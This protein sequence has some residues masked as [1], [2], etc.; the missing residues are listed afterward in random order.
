MGGD[1]CTGITLHHVKAMGSIGDM[2]WKLCRG[3]EGSRKSIFGPTGAVLWSKALGV[4]E[5]F[6]VCHCVLK[7]SES[8]ADVL[9]I[10]QKPHSAA[11]QAVPVEVPSSDP[12]VPPTRP[13]AGETK[14]VVARRLCSQSLLPAPLSS[15]GNTLVL[16]LWLCF[17]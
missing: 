9:Q 5:S 16:L 1:G 4:A 8:G 12:F 15:T 11:V 7:G 3:L 10:L 14:G 6:C 17:G 13:Q 2:S